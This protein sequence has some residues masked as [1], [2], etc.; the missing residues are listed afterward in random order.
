MRTTHPRLQNESVQYSPVLTAGL[1][2]G[3][4]P[5]NAVIGPGRNEFDISLHKGI[6]LRDSAHLQ[7]W[8]ETYNLIQ[9]SI[10]RHPQP[11]RLHPEFGQ[12]SSVLS[13]CSE[14]KLLVRFGI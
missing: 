8:T 4:A 1:T 7:I 3:T 6:T 5:R 10:F 14:D 9:Q 12:I 13:S 2:L 11:D